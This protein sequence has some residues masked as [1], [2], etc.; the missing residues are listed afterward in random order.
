MSYVIY[1]N[2]IYREATAEE[3]EARSKETETALSTVEERV[4]GLETETSQLT[5]LVGILISGETEETA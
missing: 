5:E 4:A 1:E 2:G 3:I